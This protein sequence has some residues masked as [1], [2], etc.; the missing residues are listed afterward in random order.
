VLPTLPKN[1]IVGNAAVQLPH[2]VLAIAGLRYEGGITL[3][4]TTYNPATKL[5]SVSYATVDL[6]AVIPVRSGLTVHAGVRNLLDRNYYY[7]A[8]FPEE[9]RNWFLNLRYRF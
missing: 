6:G 5:F 7:T 9:G 1:K 3:Q 8:G 4:D 2:Q